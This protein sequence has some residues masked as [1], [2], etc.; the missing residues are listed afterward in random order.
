MYLGK[1]FACACLVAGTMSVATVA[2]AQSVGFGAGQ[3]GSQNY[4][5]NGAL[6]KVAT[7]QAGLD[8]RV[9]SYGGTGAYM[10]LIN[11][12]ELDFAA[13]VLPSVRDAL[14]G[15]G[16]FDGLS[17]ENLRLVGI[18][19]P[20][21]VG[22]MVRADSD[23]NSIEDL[24]GRK[25]TYGY[26]SQPSLL[27]NVDGLLANG[28]LTPDDIDQ[29]LVP[30]VGRGVEDF[31]AGGVDAAFF[32]LRGGKAKEADAALGGIRWIPLSDSDEAVARMQAVLPTSY[33]MT[34]PPSAGQVGISEPIGVMAYDYAFVSAAHVPDD[35]VYAMVKAMIENPDA[36][37]AGG[38][39][40]TDFDPSKMVKNTDPI[41]Y[42]PGA[43]KYFK[44]AGLW[45]AE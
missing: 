1:V 26:A 12:G 21:R 28:G 14:S 42:H 27:T 44:E 17:M 20:T 7:E 31:M 35:V 6:A 37:I 23:I 38:R 24:R 16:A 34:E 25:V 2:S 10:P 36:V 30:S 4:A 22:F 5:V 9:Q 33:V 45:S 3:Q 15:T 43:V 32:A 8:A 40:L 29:V 39:A 41:P 18:L 11:N 13:V 19:A